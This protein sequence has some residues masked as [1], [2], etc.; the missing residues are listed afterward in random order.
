MFGLKNYINENYKEK[1]MIFKISVNLLKICKNQFLQKREK[2]K[3]IEV[4]I[5]SGTSLSLQILGSLLKRKGAMK[6]SVNW[7]QYIYET[8]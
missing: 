5:L 2:K 8:N 7:Y 4:R 3:E 6:L 1:D